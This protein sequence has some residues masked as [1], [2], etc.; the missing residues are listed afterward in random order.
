MPYFGKFNFLVP[1]TQRSPPYT[2]L[3]S[4]LTPQVNNYV[5]K[6]NTYNE[7]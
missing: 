4:S 1:L 6:N 2:N 5:H 7:R 3:D